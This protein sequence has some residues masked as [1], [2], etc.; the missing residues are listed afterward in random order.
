VS[1]LLTALLL[2]SGPVLPAGTPV[3]L[4]TR[5]DLSSR[6]AAQGDPVELE[7]AEDVRVDGKLVIAR[8]SPAL[9]EVALRRGHGS[10]GRAGRLEIVLSHV[11]I[12]D[13]PVRLDGRR[14]ARGRSARLPAVSAGIAI[15]GLAGIVI[16]GGL[17]VLPAGSPITGFVHRDVPLAPAPLR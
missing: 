13:R 2:A 15:S 8:G 11:M 9:G 5:A 6:T 12:G 14:A 1:L 10:Y 17:A 7:T 3:R 16:K 4:V